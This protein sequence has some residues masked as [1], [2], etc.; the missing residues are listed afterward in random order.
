MRLILFWKGMNMEDWFVTSRQLVKQKKVRLET[1]SLDWVSGLMLAMNLGF[2]VEWLT[3]NQVRWIATKNGLVLPQNPFPSFWGENQSRLLFKT[4]LS[5]NLVFHRWMDLTS[6][7]VGFARAWVALFDDLSG[8]VQYTW[9]TSI[10]MVWARQK[11][12][13]YLSITCTCVRWM[14]EW[15][16]SI[17]KLGWTPF[18]EW[19]RSDQ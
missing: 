2:F 18:F 17:K 19:F 1:Q 4:N 16:E 6:E 14:S 10:R 13:D 9:K 12:A 7:T 15:D 5:K 8:S 11:A 3:A